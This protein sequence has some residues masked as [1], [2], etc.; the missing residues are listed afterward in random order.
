VLIGA[1]KRF[2]ASLP[3]AGGHF[4]LGK[5]AGRFGPRPSWSSV[6][7]GRRPSG[8]IFERRAVGLAL[9]VDLE[10]VASPS[11]RARSRGVQIILSLVAEAELRAG[12][13]QKGCP[14]RTALSD[15]GTAAGRRFCWRKT[16]QLSAAAEPV[17]G[18]S[19]AGSVASADARDRRRHRRGAR[20]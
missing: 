20:R 14:L 19:G 17:T 16:R 2:R 15:I 18:R 8:G 13:I 7:A 12:S 1:T 3:V 5:E 4:T 11:R 6:P 10:G 9:R